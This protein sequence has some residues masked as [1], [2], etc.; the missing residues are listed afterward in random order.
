MASHTHDKDHHAVS[1][2]PHAPDP[3]EIEHIEQHIKLY[4]I[5]FGSLF[6]L[7]IITVLVAYL[8]F[9]T[10]GHIICALIIATFKA[11]LVVAV[12]MHMMTEKKLIYQVMIG[13]VVC[14]FILFFLTWFA[15]YD[16]IHWGKDPY[17]ER[18]ADHVVPAGHPTVH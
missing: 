1:S 2:D 16:P 4:W 5:I 7:T 13:A 10:W 12:F 17:K 18:P 9:S 11:G 6:V 14:A 8:P 3:H 15:W